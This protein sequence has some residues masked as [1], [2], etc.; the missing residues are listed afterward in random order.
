MSRLATD[1]T[2]FP[3]TTTAPY[4]PRVQ[5][6][7][8]AI[9]LA[10]LLPGAAALAGPYGWRH[11]A[12][13]LV[14]G[15]LGLVLYHAAFGFT[16]AFRAFASVGDTRGLRAQMLMLAV[17][18]VLFAPMLSVGT[19]FGTEVAGAVA[20]A[21]VGVLLGAAVFAIGM[22]LAGGCGSGCLF[23][24]GGGATSMI[25]ALVGFAAGSIVA[26]LHADLWRG[27]PSLGP[28]SLGDALGWLPA[29][30][31]QLAAFG[32]I[33]LVAKRWE[34]RRLGDVRPVAPPVRG[35]RRLLHGPWSLA[36]GAIA[37]AALNAVVV[38]LSGHAWGITWG[39]T[40]AGAKA[41]RA[42]GVDVAAIDFWSDG[43]PADALAASVFADETAMMDAAIVLGAL[44]G[45][46]LAGRFHVGRV[47]VRRGAIALAG[48]LLLGYGARLAFGCNIGA[49]FSGI[50]STSLHGWLWLAGAL[51]GTPIGVLLRRRAGLD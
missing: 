8:V 37:L 23:N 19:V 28:I 1:R 48:G 15:A 10:L 38:V 47:T 7:V 14:G 27:L 49:Y 13:F 18:T 11:A 43:F 12:L 42:L 20:P 39:I 4:A 50:A 6:R 45:A 35:W 40:L 2:G 21:G 36:G 16:A 17:A 51:L 9:A 25:V 26:T 29:V 34:R 46:G 44:L 30:A 33:A 24:L 31:L 41:L 32:V 22:Q 5:A 3:A